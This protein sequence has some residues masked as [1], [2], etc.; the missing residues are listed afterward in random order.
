[1]PNKELIIKDE[2][3]QEVC[4]IV[5]ESISLKTFLSWWLE[6]HGGYYRIS[7]EKSNGEQGELVFEPFRNY[8]QDGILSKIYYIHFMI[9]NHSG[10]KYEKVFFHHQSCCILDYIWGE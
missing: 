1:M 2:G 7:C 4:D 3:L 10:I 8:N 6:G 9:K 5:K